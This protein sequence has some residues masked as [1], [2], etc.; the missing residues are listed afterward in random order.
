MGRVDCQRSFH[1]NRLRLPLHGIGRC[2]VGLSPRSK[3]VVFEI[4]DAGV[5]QLAR[6]LSDQHAYAAFTKMDVT[7]IDHIEL[8]VGL[9]FHCPRC[10]YVRDAPY[11]PRGGYDRAPTLN[12]MR[13]GLFLRASSNAKDHIVSC[14]ESTCNTSTVFRYNTLQRSYKICSPL[15]R[16]FVA[17]YWVPHKKSRITSKR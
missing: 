12:S 17:D 2:C 4:Q 16:A 15:S 14:I 13:E 11:L 3:G 5:G 10:H 8:A 6:V 7:Q 9:I 1:F